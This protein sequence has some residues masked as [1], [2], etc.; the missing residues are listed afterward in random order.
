MISLRDR[1][2]PRTNLGV[3]TA[4]IAASQAFI[5]TCG[6]LAWLAPM[7]GVRT[8]A[9]YADDRLLMTH[10]YLAR[11]MFHR[12]DAAPFETLDLRAV[13]ELDVLTPTVQEVG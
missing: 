12:M 9:V 8:I 5:G 3:Q 4:V 11:Q 7:L 13:G 1:L 2:E 6:S 10:L